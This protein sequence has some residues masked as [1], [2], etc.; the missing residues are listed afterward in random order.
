MQRSLLIL[1]GSGFI[2]SNLAD[3]ALKEGYETHIFFNNCSSLRNKI[4]GAIYTQV[5]LTNLELLREKIPQDLDYLV[6]LSG[7]I[8]HSPFNNGGSQIIDTHLGGTINLLKATNWK[9]LKRFVQIGSS[10]EYGGNLSPLNEDLPAAPISPY[11]FSKSAS[12]ELLKMLHKTESFPSVM[13][14]L[15]LVFGPRQDSKRFLPQLIK[16]CLEDKKIP[17]SSGEQLR[18]FCY[19][20][21]IVEGILLSLSCEDAVGEIINLGSGKP[22]SIKQMINRVH[23][24]IG[25]GKP[26]FGE[27]AH[28]PQENMELYADVTKAKELLGWEERIGLEEG[29]DRTINHYRNEIS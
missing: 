16:G 23:S 5:D 2:G 19:V 15:F 1:G 24:Q 4:E 3:R 10:D 18:D 28:R 8:D 11:A 13:L 7:Y 22:I 12:I 9:R 26:V 6:N 17:V 14:R 27:I 20:E 25:S 29:L 21:N